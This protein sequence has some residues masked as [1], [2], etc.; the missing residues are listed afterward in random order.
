[1]SRTLDPV[2]FAAR[3]DSYVDAAEGL[4]RSGG[5]ASVSVADVIAA[6]GGSKG[7]FYHYFASKEELLAAV[8]ARLTSTT[9]EAIAALVEDEGVDAIAAFGSIVHAM[10]AGRPENRDLML[11]LLEVWYR[12]DNAAIREASRQA[13][14][15]ALAPLLGALLARGREQGSLR[16]ASPEG[17]ADVLAT[18]LL[19]M[20]DAASRL[21][22]SRQSDAVSPD[23]AME[24]LDAY[25]EGMER[26]L[27]VPS[28]TAFPRD[29]ELLRSWFA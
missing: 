14:H 1:V 24:V 25:A 4:L 12:D 23:A 28:G 8:V 2:A 6:A 16:H 20:N 13:A 22:L 26:V 3:R 10:P 9:A 29:R 27:G 21:W 15:A 19:G 7:A 17:S 11:G 5:Y 18:L